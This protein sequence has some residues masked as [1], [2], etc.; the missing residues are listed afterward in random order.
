MFWGLLVI[1]VLIAG[2]WKTY[3]RF[4]VP[5]YPATYVKELTAT[6][7]LERVHVLGLRQRYCRLDVVV[8]TWINLS[9][10]FPLSDIPQKGDY[11][12]LYA[13]I[14]LCMAAQIGAAGAAGHI[15]YRA[16]E[17]RSQRWFLTARP[18]PALSCGGRLV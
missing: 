3:T 11:V 7:R 8:H 5:S 9:P 17:G 13:P 6:G 14:D 10:G 16:G 2:G 15:L 18:S 12:S 4:V 1:A